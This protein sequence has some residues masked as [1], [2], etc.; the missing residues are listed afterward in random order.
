MQIWD[1]SNGQEKQELAGHGEIIQ[2]VAWS[3]QGDSIVTAC[4]DKKLR[5]FDVRAKKVA[6]VLI[7]PYTRKL[8]DIKVSR[9][10]V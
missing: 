5:L 6:Q 10:L 3:W 9:D 4:K 7:N 1:I 2:S 8:T